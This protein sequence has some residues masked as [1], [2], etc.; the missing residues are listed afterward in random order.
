MTTASRPD[1]LVVVALAVCLL[2]DPR[3]E[4]AVRQIWARLESRGIGSLETHTHGRHHP[5]LSY[6]V[7]QDW[8]FAAVSAAMMSLPDSGSFPLAVHGTVAFPR[9]RVA[10]APSVSS[11]VVRRQEA[12]VA[13]L[14]ATGARL[15]KHYEPGQWVPHCSLSPD[16]RGPALAIV[17]KAVTDVLPLTLEVS[18]A[19]LVDSATGETWPL[20]HL[21]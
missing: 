19:A 17:A 12:V 3:G 9:G 1:T 7:M 5:H 13:A 8:D 15:H 16:A 6:A 4:A 14:K 11:D 18:R 21:P 10:L 20:P 2:F